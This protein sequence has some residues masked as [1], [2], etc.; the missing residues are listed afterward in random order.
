MRERYDKN[1]L[2]DGQSALLQAFKFDF[3]GLK[4]VT[5]CYVNCCTDI[6]AASLNNDL[7]VAS[8][9]EKELDDKNEFVTEV[10][11]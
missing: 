6:K 7:I 11:R 8:R 1:E 10:C 2:S 9:D 3:H 5:S 4:S